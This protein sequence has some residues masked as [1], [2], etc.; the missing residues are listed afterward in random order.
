MKHFRTMLYLLIIL[1]LQ[2]YLLYAQTGIDNSG[3]PIK[4]V[5]GQEI[6]RVTKNDENK[7]LEKFTDVDT[8]IIINRFPSPADFVGDLAFDGEYLW[9]EGYNT[10]VVYKISPVDGSIVKTIP[11]SVI[12]PYGL[13]FDNQY[14]WLADNDNYEIQKIDTAT[15]VVI[16]SFPAPTASTNGYPTG[17]AWD[18]A[19][20][21]HNDTGGPQFGNGPDLTFQIDNSGQTL[22][23]FTAIGAY[24]TGL[25]W[26]GQYLW[27]S[28][29]VLQQIHQV[30]PTNFNILRTIAAPGG[31]YPNGLAWDGQYLWVSNNDADSIYQLDVGLTGIEE[32]ELG[33][34]LPYDFALFQNYPN[35]FNPSTK[36]RYEIPELSFITLKVYDV[37]GSEIAVLVNEEKPI[38]THTIDFDATNLPSGIYFYQLQTPNFTQTKKMILLK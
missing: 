38:G 18:G 24:P 5:M 12:R 7:S 28:D 32:G 16:Q 25:T 13:T 11:T 27:T 14:L 10:S 19:N 6:E 20:L 37:L 21:W 31:D 26:D 9:V 1:G 29:N 22:Q 2:N 3:N 34:A 17:L 23:T 15:G 36:I 35:P 30:D 33:D 4:S 8:V